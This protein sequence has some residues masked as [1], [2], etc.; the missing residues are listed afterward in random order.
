MKN[1]LDAIDIL[2]DLIDVD[3]LKSLITGN[4]YNGDRPADSKF[5]DVTINAITLGDGNIQ[6]GTLNVNCHVPDLQIKTPDLVYRIKNHDRLKLII[7][8]AL[9][10]LNGNRGTF[11]KDGRLWV[12]NISGPIAQPEIHQHYVNIRVEMKLHANYN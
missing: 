5:E 6:R 9:T 8:T 3:E 7:S 11:W 12:S 1:T 4:V 10:I 2:Y